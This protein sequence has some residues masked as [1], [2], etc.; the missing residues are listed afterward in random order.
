MPL[1]LLVS[2]LSFFL[3]LQN[4]CCSLE[5]SNQLLEEESI[6][7]LVSYRYPY[8]GKFFTP[9]HFI[10]HQPVC[11]LGAFRKFDPISLLRKETGAGCLAQQ[12][13]ATGKAS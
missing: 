12:K 10:A 1:P 8:R 3:S 9:T 13:A 2:S 11:G 4:G 7:G 5:F 6:I